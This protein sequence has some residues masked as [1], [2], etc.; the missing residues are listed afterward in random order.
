MLVL[1]GLVCG[2]GRAREVSVGNCSK[3]PCQVEL[4]LDGSEMDTLLAKAGGEL[5]SVCVMPYLSQNKGG[6]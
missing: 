4:I 2:S 3:V 6:H 1:Q 5:G